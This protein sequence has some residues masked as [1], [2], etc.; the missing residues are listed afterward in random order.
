MERKDLWDTKAF[1]LLKGGRK[2]SVPWHLEHY[3][4]ILPAGSMGLNF[5]IIAVF[6]F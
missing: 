5:P 3:R 6:I 4:A 2:E 1:P